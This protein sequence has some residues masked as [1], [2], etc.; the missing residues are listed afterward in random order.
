MIRYVPAGLFALAAAVVSAGAAGEVVEPETGIPFSDTLFVEEAGESHVLRL[1]GTAVRE[2]TVFKLDV[3]A[4]GSYVGAGEA[5]G[6]DPA[7]AIVA[8]EAPKR[9]VMEFVRD[10]E[11]DRVTG[12]YREGIEKNFGDDTGAFAAD[13]ETLLA[14]FGDDV[15]SGDRL[16]LTY[17]PGTGIF[18]RHGERVS[19]PLN[20]PALAR[21]VWTIWFGDDPVSKD[22]RERMAGPGS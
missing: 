20:N 17:L 9:I 6:D 15:A 21:A 18:A 13:L 10:V 5:L 3:Y 16:V 11:A 7:A 4:V 19:D 8:A 12:A 1:T 14:F 2:A 22:M